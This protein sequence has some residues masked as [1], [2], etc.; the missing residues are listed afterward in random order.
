MEAKSRILRQMDSAS[1]GL[2]IV[3][4]KFV[5]QVILTQTPGIIS[6]PR[7]RADTSVTYPHFTD[8]AQRPEQ[9]EI[10]LALV[11]QGHQLLSASKLEAEASGLLDRILGILQENNE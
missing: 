3:C 10:S 4:V 7:V 11:P 5:Q 8:C 1:A 6:D 9:N 2:R